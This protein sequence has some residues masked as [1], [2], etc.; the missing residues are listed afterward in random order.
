MKSKNADSYFHLGR[1]CL[2]RRRYVDAVAAYRKA[3]LLNPN[4]SAAHCDLADAYWALNRRDEAVLAYRKAIVANPDDPAVHC[5][6]GRACWAMGQRPEAVRALQ[7]A[8][9]IDPDGDVGRE[10]QDLLGLIRQS[11][12]GMRLLHSNGNAG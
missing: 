2:S 4:H 9:Q 5:S 3:L 11:Q 8:A 1:A 12:P 7:R 10:A 6:M